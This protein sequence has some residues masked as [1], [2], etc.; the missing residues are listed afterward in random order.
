[1][2]ADRYDFAGLPKS[3][4]HNHFILG[5]PRSVYRSI[6]G[7]A[8]VDAI[9][10]R[11]NDLPHFLRFLRE[12]FF[13][14]PMRDIAAWEA[15][16][17]GC[18]EQLVADRVVYAEVSFNIN[19][20]TF[21]G[22]SWAELAERFSAIVERFKNEIT[23]L[24]EVGIAREL[25]DSIWKPAAR[26]ALKTGFFKSADLYGEE[27]WCDV[28]EFDEFFSLARDNGLKVK[29]HS[30]ETGDPARLLSEVKHVRPDALQH[31]VRA[32][33]D[34]RVM[35]YLAKLEI[36]LNVCPTSNV[37]L[38]VTESYQTHPIRRLYDAGVI[39]TLNSDDYAIFDS[40][41]SDEYRCLQEEGIFSD[42]ELE[43]IRLNGLRQANS[44]L[45]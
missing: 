32:G 22:Y 28:K 43:T 1:M 31:G 19:S 15:I 45:A 4:L 35:E 25:P 27:L 9:P 23:I 30:G 40:S 12:H 14:A 41:V 13:P 18:L 36:P 7:D 24:P 10:G 42:A 8:A 3:D 20:D 39:V 16:F 29:L 38:R 6:I 17:A 34:P 26:A 33:E 44:H 11:F 37:K 5:A 2:V 21:L